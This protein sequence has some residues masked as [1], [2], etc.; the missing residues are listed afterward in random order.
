MSRFIRR[1]FPQFSG[2]NH[3]PDSSTRSN[4]LTVDTTNI[5]RHRARVRQVD[6]A[7][8]RRHKKAKAGQSRS[9]AHGV[10]QVTHRK[11]ADAF[12][13]TRH[14]FRVLFLDEE[15]RYSPEDIDLS[16]FR[17]PGGITIIYQPGANL[18]TAHGLLH[19]MGEFFEPV[20]GDYP[21]D[22]AFDGHGIG[23][24]PLHRADPVLQQWPLAA[25]SAEA[26]FQVYDRDP[27]L[28][29]AIADV[30]R[31]VGRLPQLKAMLHGKRHQDYFPLVCMLVLDCLAN[32]T[33]LSNVQLGRV[34]NWDQ[35]LREWVPMVELYSGVKFVPCPSE[36]RAVHQPEIAFKVTPSIVDDVMQQLAKAATLN[37]R[38][39]L[40]EA[41]ADGAVYLI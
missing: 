18:A 5:E 34:T 24:F 2:S 26:F 10:S 12:Q 28:R 19:Q 22:N 27:V 6:P 3:G 40:D 32:L 4:P 13:N 23:F 41:Q 39:R 11:W 31:N 15:G 20:P 30:L 1:P 16:P 25:L 21:Y 14:T 37:I 7:I 35:I 8:A 38:R 17:Q 29:A 36:L 9:L 33:Q